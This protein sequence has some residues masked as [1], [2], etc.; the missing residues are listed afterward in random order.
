MTIDDLLQ[1]ESS[2]ELNYSPG[3]FGAKIEKGKLLLPTEVYEALTGGGEYRL[4]LHYEIV[5]VFE[6]NFYDFRGDVAGKLGWS[7]EEVETAY[8]SFFRQTCRYI[9][10]PILRFIGKE[11]EAKRL[12]ELEKKN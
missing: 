6:N 3:D 1:I 5:S 2:A 12:Q 10:E 8:Q 4:E 9:P 11:E 7:R